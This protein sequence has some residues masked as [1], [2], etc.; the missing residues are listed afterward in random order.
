[1]TSRL[2]AALQ[3]LDGFRSLAGR[4]SDAPATP[5]AD[6][7]YRDW[8]VENNG[9]VAYDGCL[10]LFPV[11]SSEGLVDLDSWNAPHGWKESFADLAPSLSI[12]GEDAFGLQFA[13]SDAGNVVIFWSETGELESLG[14]GVREFLLRI[15]AD[16]DGT[17]SYNLHRQ[18]IAALGSLQLNQHFA[19]KV[20]T[21]LGGHL[22]LDNLTVVDA[23]AH[24]RALGKIALQ[25]R[26][27]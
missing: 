1:M 24:M 20:E 7:E 2:A 15:A 23:Q 19:F 6:D 13:F 9:G 4:V 12:F 27:M 18:G 16:P 11:R 10:R 26:R 3:A 14:Y 21:A 5:L 8:I 25:L 22:S 17:I